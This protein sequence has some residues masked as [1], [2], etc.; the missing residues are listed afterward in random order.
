MNLSAQRPIIVTLQLNEARTAFF[1]SQRERYFPAHINYIGAHLTLFHNLPGERFDLILETIGRC[2]A[3]RAAFDIG[4][5]GVMRLGRGVAYEIQSDHLLELHTELAATFASWLTRQ[6]KERF[7]PH[8]TVQNKV[9]PHEADALYEHLKA[10]FSS[11]TAR[12]EGIQLWFYEGGR[13]RTGTWASAGAI[14]FQK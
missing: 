3:A 7:R 14:A 13:N 2:C 12:A 8:I 10:N 9:P 6:D 5:S 4:V 1:Q 11:F